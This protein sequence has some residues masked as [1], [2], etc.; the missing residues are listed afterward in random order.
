MVAI[1]YMNNHDLD[2]PE[3]VELLSTGF[4]GTLRG[5]WDS[6]LTKD[7]RESIKRAVKLNDEG[8]PIFDEKRNSG[9]PDG[10]NTLIHTILKHFVGTL[11]NVS[12]RVSDYLNN[13]RCPTMSDYR[14]YHAV[15]L[16]RVMLRKDCKK[17][18][19]KEK[20]ID[21]LPP[22]FAH[23]IQNPELQKE[24]L[25]RFK[26][27]LTK[28]EDSKKLKSTISFEEVLERFNKKK[29][30]EL[31]I[32]DLKQK[33]NIVESNIDY[34]RHEL[35]TIKTDN[36]NIK[37]ELSI[38]KL[39]K[40]IDKHQSDNEQDEP[41]EGNDPCQQALFPDTGISD[42]INSILNNSIP[43]K[44]FTKLNIVVSP[45]YNFD[46]IAMIDS[47]ADMN[48]IQEDLIPPEYFEYS[49]ERLISA[50]GSQMKIKHE[51]PNA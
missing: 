17:P 12:S 39:D 21:G 3:I 44:W 29:P 4:T 45:T 2:H 30:K 36:N 40:S 35:E 22:L 51:L 43:P 42:T 32:G 1:T 19:W 13:L 34:L 48:C 6:Y 5:W 28:N 23:K 31:T 11:T 7:S 10:V 37:Q 8:L 33:L 24:Y 38:L 18:Y 49:S 15:F 26:K 50:N 9:I 25:D 16:S 41:K 14:W 46:V 20:F 47:G 27:N